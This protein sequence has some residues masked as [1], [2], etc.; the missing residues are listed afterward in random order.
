[1]LPILTGIILSAFAFSEC[2]LAAQNNKA[3]APTIIVTA[4]EITDKTLTLRYEIK[5]SSENDIWICEDIAVFQHDFDFEVF[6]TEDDQTLLIRRRLDISPRTGITAP[7]GRYMRLKTGQTRTESLLLPLPIQLR[8][9]FES[10]AITQG[11][12][13]P[14]RLSIEIGYYVGDFPDI[15]CEI[16]EK[17]DEMGLSNAHLYLINR[18]FGGF[19]GFIASNSQVR[20]KNEEVVIPHTDRAFMREEVSRVTIEG[21]QIPYGRKLSTRGELSPPDLANCTRMEIRYQPSMLEYFFPYEAQQSLLCP[22]EIQYLQSLKDL[23]VNNPEKLKAL[24]DELKERF[25]CGGIITERSIAHV[26]CYRDDEHLTS[27]TIYD[28]TSVVTEEKQRLRYKLGLRTLKELTPQIQP[29]QLRLECADNLRDLWLLL[30]FLYG[31]R[32]AYP[33]SKWCTTIIQDRRAGDI[34]EEYR[35]GKFKCPAAGEGKCHYAMN[36]NCELNST[37]D[38]VLLFETKGGW[39]QHGGP[40]LFTFDNHDPKGGCVILNDGTVKFIRTKEELQQLQWK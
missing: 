16:L 36:P 15:I 40:E 12:V 30:R 31:S 6:L 22:D 2:A 39:N 24:A 18:W 4:L 21:L 29:F 33:A 37:P 34:S 13:Y 28:D 3:D 11:I 23:N 5:N 14:K 35:M 32:N 38:T 19:W 10:G 1:M 7:S 25:S 27:F 8:Y 20:D 17:A 9:L 26:V